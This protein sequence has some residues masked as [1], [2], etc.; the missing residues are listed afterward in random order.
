MISSKRAMT[1]CQ[2]KGN[3][4]YFETSA[5]EAVNVEQAFEGNFSLCFSVYAISYLTDNSHCTKCTCTRRGRRVQQRWLYRP[6]QHPT[7][8]RAGWLRLLS[9][10]TTS[11]NHVD[12]FL[13]F[14]PTRTDLS[15]IAGLYN[16]S[17]ID[18]ETL[19]KLSRGYAALR[20][21]LFAANF[22]IWFCYSFFSCLILRGLVHVFRSLGYPFICMLLFASFPL[23][24]VH[25]INED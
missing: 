20:R 3:L 7:W 11:L 17:S 18:S 16:R 4:P 10:I 9:Y 15:G 23:F 14:S 5:K 1:F 24:W 13:L 21:W 6:Y 12:T 2:S 8:Q 19:L 25:D 22:Y